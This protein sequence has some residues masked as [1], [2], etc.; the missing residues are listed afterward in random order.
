MFVHITISTT[1]SISSIVHK[2][3]KKLIVL[4]T[5]QNHIFLADKNA[6][7]PILFSLK[8]KMSIAH[9]VIQIE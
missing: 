2:N 1:G 4:Y 9:V 7:L 6:H 3:K 8:K 5:K